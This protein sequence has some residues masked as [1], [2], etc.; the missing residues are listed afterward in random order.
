M[1]PRLLSCPYIFAVFFC[2]LQIRNDRYEEK[3][4][5]SRFP[6]LFR[7]I[8]DYGIITVFFSVF[9]LC[10]KNYLIPP[11]FNDLIEKPSSALPNDLCSMGINFMLVVI[12]MGILMIYYGVMRIV[13]ST[14]K[15]LVRTY[16][17][18]GYNI[19]NFCGSRKRSRSDVE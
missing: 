19:S 17:L 4:Q 10:L 5:S 12:S 16:M 7:T 13:Q 1:F 15:L 8:G 18:F 6:S 9:L 14:M 3:S 11:R 2:A